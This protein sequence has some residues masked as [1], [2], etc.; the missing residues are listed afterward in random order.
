MQKFRP[1]DRRKLSRGIYCNEEVRGDFRCG[2]AMEAVLKN[3]NF[4]ECRLDGMN[5]SAAKMTNCTFEKC[6]LNGAVLNGSGFINCDFLDCDMD[7][8]RFDGA[9]LQNCRFKGG[10]AE[11]SS[12]LEATV[13]D[14]V[15][16]LQLHGADLRFSEA[17]NVDYGQ[18][19]LWA[20]AINVNCTQ[21]LRSRF[22]ERQIDLFLGLVARA[23]PE[24]RRAEI[25]SIIP[26]KSLETLRAVLGEKSDAC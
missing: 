11:Y 25:E 24:E 10:R 14:S 2:L 13:W 8:A 21:F 15:F 6:T 3:C 19:N 16:D 18:S 9:I 5:L 7:M 4:S 17:R 1:R 22:S 23:S 26:E 20:A 12:F